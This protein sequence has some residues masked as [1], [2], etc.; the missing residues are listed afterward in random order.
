MVFNYMTS[1]PLVY[2]E[3]ASSFISYPNLHTKS[4]PSLRITANASQNT[5]KMGISKFIKT[6][7]CASQLELEQII[8]FSGL[9]KCEL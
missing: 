5:I 9:Q 1:G 4:L 6:L 8:Y 3:T 7:N 2:K